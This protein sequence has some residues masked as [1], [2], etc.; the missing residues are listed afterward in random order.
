MTKIQ[1]WLVALIAAAS[2]IFGGRAISA[3][4]RYSVRIPNGLAFSEFSGYEKWQVVAVS[5]SEEV[6]AAQR[7]PRFIGR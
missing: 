1:I 7:S 5:Q 6:M 4:D 3:Q 2:T